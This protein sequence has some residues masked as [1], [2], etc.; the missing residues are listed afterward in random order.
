MKNLALEYLEEAEES[1]ED[2]DGMCGELVDAM[3]HWYGEDRH[4]GILYISP[5]SEYEMIRTE[6][7]PIGWC[8]HMVAIIDD[9]VHDPWYPTLVLP[10]DEYVKSAFPNQRL[11]YEVTA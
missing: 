6:H 7:D 10:P 4:V 9:L 2:Y 5:P 3:I 1:L 8:Y 11:D